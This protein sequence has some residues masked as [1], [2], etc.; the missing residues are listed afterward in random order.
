MGIGT[1]LSLAPSPSGWCC[2]NLCRCM[3]W[4]IAEGSNAAGLE[5]AFGGSGV[6]LLAHQSQPVACQSCQSCQSSPERW[7][8][9]PTHPL[10]PR[11]AC[12]MRGAEEPCCHGCL[13]RGRARWWCTV[14]WYT[15][16]CTGHVWWWLLR[17]HGTTATL[18]TAPLATG[19]VCASSNQVST[20]FPLP[21][22]AVMPTL[23]G[24]RPA[25]VSK[26]RHLVSH[27]S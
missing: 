25:L 27:F 20:L 13:G 12:C 24:P 23:R 4:S 18:P 8:R 11:I 2:A 10:L 16:A 26:P 14:L 9:R 6:P 19:S 15:T 5:P 1:A 3:V 22:S 17:R 21:I 7:R